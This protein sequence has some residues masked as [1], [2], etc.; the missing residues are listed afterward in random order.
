MRDNKAQM[1]YG[2]FYDGKWDTDFSHFIAPWLTG[3]RCLR[4]E[5]LNEV[6]ENAAQGYGFETALTL[7]AQKHKWV[8]RS[9]PMQGVTHMVKENHRGLLRGLRNRAA[10]WS[11]IYRA[12]QISRDGSTRP[13]SINLSG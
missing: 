1:T 6:P 9:I 8:S 10:M 13:S 2:L 7:A 3:Q 12:W 5:L 11:D 4:S